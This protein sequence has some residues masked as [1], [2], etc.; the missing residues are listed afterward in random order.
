VQAAATDR[1]FSRA[2]VVADAIA[3]LD[4][5]RAA[6]VI[7]EGLRI[8]RPRSRVRQLLRALLRI[9]TGEALPGRR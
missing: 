1:I 4:D 5:V 6:I 9:E 7:K 2:E 3:D 8:A